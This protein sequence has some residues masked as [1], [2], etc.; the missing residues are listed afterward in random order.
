MVTRLNGLASGFET[1]TT[2]TA[3]MKAARIPLTKLA[4]KKQLL[5]W[6]RDDYRTLN[7]KILELRTAASD[8]KIP[9][10][11]QSKTAASS[12]DSSVSVTGSAAANAG[13]YKIKVNQ[14]ATAAS[15][16]SGDLAG[17]GSDTKTLGEIGLTG[18]TTLTIKGEKG[19]KT[20][21]LKTTDSMAQFVANFNA[22][23]SSTGVKAN[24]DSAMDRMFFV[25]TSTGANSTVD[26]KVN[27]GGVSNIF[28]T[29]RPSS[30]NSGV[31]V[32][33][34]P[35][36]TD[37]G[38]LGLTTDT[39]LNITGKNGTQTIDLKTTDTISDFLD[40]FNE[41]T[42]LT[43]VKASYDSI[44]KRFVFESTPAG[45]GSIIDISVND[46][47]ASDI[48]KMRTNPSDPATAVPLRAMSSGLTDTGKDAKISFN[49]IDTTYSSNNF[50]IIGINFTAK[51][52]DPTVELNITV[53]QDT[54][55][56]YNS[57]K[58][59][60]DKYN[61]LIEAVNAKKEEKRYRDFQP[62]S[63]EQKT[64]MKEDDIKSW[65]VKAMSGMLSNDQMLNSGLNSFRTA[66]SSIVQGLPTGQYKSL[67][68][69]G[70]SSSVLLGSTVSG[71]YLDKGKLFIDDT[72]LKAA[73]AD[74]P[75]QV[76]KLFLANDNDKETSTGDGIAVR[77][78]D[79][80]NQLF[81]KI[82]NKAG[83][84][85]SVQ[86]S[87]L[88]GKTLKDIDKQVD[89][90]SLRLD[91]LETRYYKQFTSMEKYINNMNTQSANLTKQFG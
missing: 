50:T 30:I 65:N 4:Q 17:V 2:V 80:A 23:S 70:I 73:I 67:S 38:E 81:A 89:T 28:N 1:E 11:Y 71:S 68:E 13:V 83:L 79:Q 12:N 63:D 61:S 85:T 46:D 39:T 43:G 84:A 44:A 76:S 6:Q 19:T 40:N 25:S 54:D 14:L 74:N 8:M 9:S 66:L 82:S 42:G 47:G 37:L 52:A 18:A 41:K 7:A 87:Y 33:I 31:V 22:E 90:L 48:F 77:M 62:L 16:T 3:L 32:V 45:G 78:Y 86:S 60:V 34:N 26:I 51:K 15:V 55:A 35:G 20:I 49:G 5:E 53:S 88:I 58:T 75:D 29:S 69:I 57:I 27:D 36:T 59:F 56:I 64:A 10:K 72:K 21:D 91:A 24:Y